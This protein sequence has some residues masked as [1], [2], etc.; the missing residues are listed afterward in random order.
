MG[1]GPF[2]ENIID[3][4]NP[5]ALIPNPF[6]NPTC[7][8]T[9]DFTTEG[10]TTKPV[11]RNLGWV[12]GF[13]SCRYELSINTS[14]TYYSNSYFDFYDYFNSTSP[15]LP[16]YTNDLYLQK[17]FDFDTSALDIYGY[18]QGEHMFIDR[19]LI[20][21][22]GLYVFL[23]I[24]DYNK[25]Y[26][27]AGTTGLSENFE[28]T[29]SATTFAKI[30]ISTTNITIDNTPNRSFYGPVDLR[31]LHVRLLNQYGEVFNLQGDFAF[32]LRITQIY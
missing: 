30:N 22:S 9:F 24:D 32:T 1:G 19:S 7:V 6:Y 2:D 15:L 28:S 13:T 16:G 8:F 14:Y 23:D 10:L 27:P 12:L 26:N 5:L 31:R 18:I 25:N 4:S 17:Y 21:N 11:Y 3:P 20:P 29:F